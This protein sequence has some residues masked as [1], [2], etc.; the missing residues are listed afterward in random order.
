M[1]S[2]GNTN[3]ASKFLKTTTWGTLIAA[4]LLVAA[5]GFSGHFGGTNDK[6]A[7]G[8]TGA[9]AKLNPFHPTS[10]S[11]TLGRSSAP[12]VE[13]SQAKSVSA[14]ALAGRPAS[15]SNGYSVVAQAA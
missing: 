2:T 7:H 9:V 11:K 14:V 13:P 5:W 10:T 15:G 12:A 6:L 3:R 1:E 8:T 4:S